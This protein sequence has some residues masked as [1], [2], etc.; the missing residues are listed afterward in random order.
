MVGRD[1]E[2]LAMDDDG[3]ILVAFHRAA[4]DAGVRD[5]PL[6]VSLVALWHDDCMLLVFNRQRACWELPGGMIDP[7]ETPRQAAIRELHE[8]TGYQVDDLAFAGFARFTLG[9]EQRPEYAA[10]YAGQATPRS[11][12]AS[13]DEITAITWWDGATPLASR[14]QPLDVCLGRLARAALRY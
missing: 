5:A 3:N 10:I 7:G 14:V 9:P 1:L 11:T 2:P 6:T 12:F 4:D 13:N 8:E